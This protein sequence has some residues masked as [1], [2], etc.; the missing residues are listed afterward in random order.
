M[1]QRPCI[2]IVDDDESFRE[3]LDALL[4]TY[5]YD[6]QLFGSAEEFLASDDWLGS[7]CLLVDVTLP[8][9]SGSA[10]LTLLQARSSTI[11]VVFVTGYDDAE[12]RTQV[13]SA[14]AIDCLCKPFEEDELFASLGKAFREDHSCSS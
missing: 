10:L 5:D 4:R 11:P 1:P 2:A 14:G 7:D 9:A 12:L 13:I 8:G 6:V 3:S